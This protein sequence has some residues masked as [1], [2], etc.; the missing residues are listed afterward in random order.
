MADYHLAQL[1]IAQM[2]TPFEDPSMADFT[3]NLERINALADQSPGF[4]WRLE[5]E[6][7]NATSL[8]PFG[9][10]LLVNLSVWED[11]D[12]LRA[13]VFKSAHADIMR[14]RSEWFD[15][16]DTDYVVLWW[17]PAG[18]RP[19]EQEAGERLDRLRSDGP[20]PDAFSFREPF[21]PPAA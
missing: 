9:D 17:V 15:R 8:R 7:G 2:R 13:F 21:D 3:A 1:N 4:V 12:S 16:M 14:R 11:L 18:H 19:T 5:D 10:D 6:D 20:G